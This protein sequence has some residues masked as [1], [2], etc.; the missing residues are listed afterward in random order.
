MCTHVVLLILT[1]KC[2]FQHSNEKYPSSGTSF[3]SLRRRSD[4]YDL[5]LLADG[6]DPVKEISCNQ[7]RKAISVALQAAGVRS[8]HATHIGR[9]AGAQRAEANGASPE[10]IARAGRWTTGVME[11]VYLT[12]FSMPALRAL[13]GF[14][15]GG[16]GYYLPRAVELPPNLER[17]V[18][19]E[20][21]KW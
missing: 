17:R 4:W 21:E 16:R 8:T 6:N 18:F 2:R 14:G 1:N 13:A 3:P 12:N 10:E 20:I 7:Q 19:P 9:K 5:P 15:S 11:S